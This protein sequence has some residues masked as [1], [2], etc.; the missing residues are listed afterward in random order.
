MTS[1]IRLSEQR[2][3]L[4][5]HPCPTCG[6]SIHRV[7]AAGVDY[8]YRTCGNQFTFVRCAGCST[9]FLSP[10]PGPADLSV[11]YP[12][13]Y[14]SFVEAR[15]LGGASPL[16][17]A[18]WSVMER[19]RAAL[20]RDLLV[21]SSPDPRT[22]NILDIGCGDGRLLRV[23]RRHGSAG[24]TLTGVEQGLPDHVIDQ[25]ALDGIE[26]HNG[27]YEELS[28]EADRFDLIVAQ[29]V[30]EHVDAPGEV[31]SKVFTELAPGGHAVLDTPNF[32]SIDRKLFRRSTWGGYHFPRH[33][34][35]FTPKT[36]TR[37]AR[38][39][40]FEVVAVQQMLSP[41]FWIM[42]LHNV[43]VRA[44]FPEVVTAR[45]TYRSLPLLGL[46]TAVELP[47]LFILRQTSNMRAILRKPA[48]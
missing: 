1:R 41:V 20:F 9:V 24:W 5:D 48:R 22:M 27:L 33:M 28:F 47:N 2:L 18:A 16:I 6:G 42:T 3:D 46:A 23:L 4:E 37:L 25:A 31:L 36:I 29:Q 8:E 15:G 39:R 38:Y 40:G 43:L 13:H 30:I 21:K 10:R 19:R 12:R 35:L 32:E 17:R 44:G 34:T 45:V 7:V 14:Y 26:I 11:I